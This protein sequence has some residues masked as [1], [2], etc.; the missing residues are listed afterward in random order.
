MCIR[1]RYTCIETNKELKENLKCC[2]NLYLIGAIISVLC[3]FN[4]LFNIYIARF[5]CG[6][7][8]ALSIFLGLLSFIFELMIISLLWYYLEIV[9]RKCVDFNS[10][11]QP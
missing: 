4:I 7:Y 8:N 3:L 11:S 6:E 9:Y 10:I 5:I 1:L 2:F